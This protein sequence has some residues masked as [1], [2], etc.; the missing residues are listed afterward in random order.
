MILLSLLAFTQIALTNPKITPTSTP[1]AI[2]TIVE[3][4]DFQDKIK[5]AV[6]KNLATAEAQLKTKLDLKS[7]SGYS[8][9][10]T[11]I[12]QTT[13]TM[14]TADNTIFQLGI[15][16]NTVFSKSGVDIKLSSL[17]IGD[18]IIAIG[19]KTSDDIINLRRLSVY[20]PTTPTS[21]KKVI[22]GTISTVNQK[23]KNI[24][25]T[26]TDNTNYTINIKSNSPIKFDDL[27]TGK[28]VLAIIKTDNKTDTVSLLKAKIL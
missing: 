12:K 27:V 18:D 28:K 6:A 16:K 7:L 8:G 5:S 25:I 24:S 9:K 13:L 1:S 11:D 2:P 17:A 23:T 10:I 20:S 14:T 19:N 3:E 22:I 26:S 15:S 4:Q 21:T